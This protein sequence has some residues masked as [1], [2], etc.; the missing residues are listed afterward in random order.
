MKKTFYFITLL[1]IIILLSSFPGFTMEEP[2]LDNDS[3][4]YGRYT[5]KHIPSPIRLFFLSNSEDPEIMTFMFLVQI[6][7]EAGTINKKSPDFIEMIQKKQNSSFLK[8]LKKHFFWTEKVDPDTFKK[9]YV[10]HKVFLEELGVQF[11]KSLK[12]IAEYSRS[13]EIQVPLTTN[14]R[15]L[16]IGISEIDNARNHDPRT[17]YMINLNGGHAQDDL[18]LLSSRNYLD[19][20]GNPYE[21]DTIYVEVCASHK[22]WLFPE[23]LEFFNRHLVMG[24]KLILELIDNPNNP[25]PFKT[26]IYSINSQ[27]WVES[28]GDN[29]SEV[30]NDYFGRTLKRDIIELR[31]Q[32]HETLSI[33]YPKEFNK[34]KELLMSAGFDHIQESNL[35]KVQFGTDPYEMIKVDIR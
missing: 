17:T 28:Y 34:I 18:T 32:K 2:L 10:P 35:P 24:G 8:E 27:K 7:E 5:T 21:F 16:G 15:S 9:K 3:L 19:I 22:V 29:V 6:A 33:I 11:P 20:D 13:G 14:F 30:Q 23:I 25:A 12:D 1:N 4:T 31:G 26:A